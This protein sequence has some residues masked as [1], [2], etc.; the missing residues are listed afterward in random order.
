MSETIRVLVADDHPIY[1]A[2][3]VGLLATADDLDVVGEG[4]DG[5][6]AVALAEQ[7]RPDV[8]VLDLQ[9]PGIDGIEATRTIGRTCPEVGVL[10]LTMYDGD[11]RVFQAMRAGARGYVVKSAAPAVVVDA[12]R[13]VGRGGAVL[14]PALTERLADWFGTLQREHGPLARLTPREREVL[15]LMA[16][17]RGNPAI[18]A[19]LGVSPKTVRNVVSSVFVKLRV[20]DRQAAIAQAKDAGLG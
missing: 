19:A 14:S 12:V 15:D 2:G 20:A 6:E 8:A 17:G 7:L 11:D 1:R 4:G 5:R 13:T 16:R 9:M 18:A 3:L 10:I